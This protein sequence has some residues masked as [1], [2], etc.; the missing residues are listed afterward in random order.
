MGEF[1]EGGKGGSEGVVAG[2]GGNWKRR[3]EEW[4]SRG[5]SL[6]GGEGEG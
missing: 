6:W 3:G 1:G 2:S 4:G 5:G